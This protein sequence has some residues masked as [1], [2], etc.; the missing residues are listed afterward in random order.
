M[1]D[2]KEFAK[3]VK[4]KYPQY[5]DVDDLTLSQKMIE[6]YPEYKT[7]VTFDSQSTGEVAPPK[8]KVETQPTQQNQSGQKQS[9]AYDKL[10]SGLQ[11]NQTNVVGTGSVP[12]APLKA[13]GEQVKKTESQKQV[14]KASQA[15]SGSGMGFGTTVATPTTSSTG[16]VTGSQVMDANL[17]L[18]TGKKQA[19]APIVSG[20][21]EFYDNE[22][23]K[24][25]AQMNADLEKAGG[26]QQ[27]RQQVL[28]QYTPQIKDLQTKS[29]QSKSIGQQFVEVTKPKPKV[30]DINLE[31]V[32]EGRANVS[33]VKES[34]FE[35][36]LKELGLD[37]SGG[38][39]ASIGLNVSHYNPFDALDNKKKYDEL[40]RA[41]NVDEVNAFKEINLDEWAKTN[42]VSEKQLS[43]LKSKQEAVKKGGK[44]DMDEITEFIETSTAYDKELYEAG[45]NGETMEDFS[46]RKKKETADA[47]LE[48]LPESMRE[49]NKELFK[50]NSD[51]RD[52]LSEYFDVSGRK[53]FKVD[54]KTGE[55]DL[56][57]LS[58]MD[59]EFVESK[60]K[61]YNSSRDKIL[62]E[63]N[64]TVNEEILNRKKQFSELSQKIS[65]AEKELQ[66][67]TDV[68]K[69]N[70]YIQAIDNAKRTKDKLES[71]IGSLQRSKTSFFS[72]SAKTIAGELSSS[73]TAKE[74]YS[75]LPENLS[76]KE[77]SD[78]IYRRL[79]EKNLELAKKYNID[80]GRLDGIG[81]NVRDWL[82]IESLGLSLTPQEKEY[83]ANQRILQSMAPIYF[84]NSTG[85]TEES[86][87]FVES[88]MSGF[89]SFVKPNTGKRFSTQT[90]IGSNQLKNI[91]EQGFTAKDLT[92]EKSLELLEKR[93]SDIPWYSAESLGQA[94]GT[95]GA[96]MADMMV[97]GAV[98]APVKGAKAVKAVISAYDKAMD[99]SK[100]G[101]Y[102]KSAVDTGVNFELTGNIIGS[103]EEELNFIS[104]F[105]G[106]L[107]GEVVGSMFKKLGSEKLTK[108]I[109][110]LFGTKSD[111]AI[112]LLKKAGELNKKGFGEIGEETTQ[113]LIGI[114]N[115]ELRERGF[116]EEVEARYGT[117]NDVMKL[118]A[119]SY[120]MGVGMGLSTS[121]NKI[122]ELESQLTEEERNVVNSV[123]N[124]V[125]ND[126]ANAT[127]EMA[128]T[129]ENVQRVES[130]E[131][132][133]TPVVNEE[134]K[135]TTTTE[136]TTVADGEKAVTETVEETVVEEKKPNIIKDKGN[137]K[138]TEYT[139]DN[140]RFYSEKEVLA[141]DKEKLSGLTLRNPSEAV[142]GYVES[143]F[144]AEKQV[145]TTVKQEAKTPFE[146]NAQEKFKRADVKSSNDAT[147]LAVTQELADLGKEMDDNNTGWKIGNIRDDVSGRLVVDVVLPDG[148]TFLMYK[149][150]GEGSGVE[151]KGEWVPLP[152]FAENGWFVKTGFNPET[153]QSFSGS[154]ASSEKFNP[155][156]NKYGSTKF[157][158]I[159]DY[160]K[161]NEALVFSEEAEQQEV[162]QEAPRTNEQEVVSEGNPVL[163]DV[164]STA[165]ALEGGDIISKVTEKI[166]DIFYTGRG[167]KYKDLNKTKGDFI[168]FSKDKTKSEWYGGDKSRVSEAFI[169][170]SEYIDLTSQEKKSE[171][172]D[173]NFTDED[174]TNLYPDLK[175]KAFGDRDVRKTYEQKLKELI[176]KK[177]E[178]LKENRFSGDNKEQKFL[179]TKAKQLGIKGIKLLDT[180]F[181]QEDI[182][183][184]AIDKSTIKTI[185]PNTVSE[186]YHKAKADGSNPELV[187]VVEELLTQK[188]QT[189]EQAETQVESQTDT[190]T[191]TVQVDEQLSETEQV[192]ESEKSAEEIEVRKADISKEIEKLENET[193][194]EQVLPSEKKE[195]TDEEILEIWNDKWK[196]K[197]SEKLPWS[198]LK[199]EAEKE[200]L[201]EAKANKKFL[202][203][204]VQPTREQLKERAFEIF[205]RNVRNAKNDGSE[206]VWEV[207]DGR[208]GMDTKYASKNID[209]YRKN[210]NWTDRRDSLDKKENRKKVFY[211]EIYTPNGYRSVEIVIPVTDITESGMSSNR[212]SIYAGVIIS[213]PDGVT[214]EEVALPI[215]A[216]AQKIV[217]V[218]DVT[219][220]STTKQ[221]KDLAIPM[222]EKIIN[223]KLKELKE[224]K[225]KIVKV[226]N[227]TKIQEL[228]QELDNLDKI[229]KEKKEAEK[230]EAEKKEAEKKEAEKKEAE[231]KEAE[232][233]EAEKKEAEKKEAEK[234]AEEVVEI[235]EKQKSKNLK[236]AKKLIEKISPRG[237]LEGYG[238]SNKATRQRIIELLTGKKPTLAESGVNNMRK[239]IL[240]ASGINTAGMSDAS[241]MK[242]ITDWAK[243]KEEKVVEEKVETQKDK[244]DRIKSNPPSNAYESALSYFIDGGKML[245][246]AIDKLYGNKKKDVSGEKKS[247]LSL[248]DNTNG[249]SIDDIAHQLWEDYGDNLGL[250]TMDFRN[251]LEGV[252]NNFNS[253]SEMVNEYDSIITKNEAE[254][255]E[256][257]I[258]REATEEIEKE[259]STI[260]N[261]ISFLED[262]ESQLDKFGKETL[263]I[264]IPV[265]ILKQAIV[266]AKKSLQAG[267]KVAEAFSD[268]KSY[269]QNT[270]WFK[271]KS[272]D[273]KD[274]IIDKFNKLVNNEVEFKDIVDTREGA[275]KPKGKFRYSAQ[276]KRASLMQEGELSAKIKEVSKY[277]PQ[278]QKE[279][280]EK[281]NELLDL[282]GAEGAIDYVTDPKNKMDADVIIA[283][284]TEGGARVM[285]DALSMK[286]EAI[287]NDDMELLEVAEN[288]I[289][290]AV[291]YID[292]ASKY[293]TKSGQINAYTARSYEKYPHVFSLVKS[294]RLN[295]KY[296]APESVKNGITDTQQGITNSVN[297]VVDEDLKDEVIESLKSKVEE[298][299]K[300]LSEKRKSRGGKQDA[301]KQKVKEIREKRKSLFDQLKNTKQ[302]SVSIAGISSEQIEIVGKI[303][304]SYIE[305]GVVKTSII[306]NDIYKSIK[307]D[308]PNIRKEHILQ[309]ARENPDFE[310]LRNAE[311]D[312][313]AK[314]KDVVEGEL[315]PSVIR[316]LVK[317]F[318]AGR[319]KNV[320]S[321]AEALAQKSGKPIDEVQTLAD[322]IEAKLND[323]IQSIV[324]KEHQKF[325]DSQNK[326]RLTTEEL[327]KKRREGKISAE[328]LAELEKRISDTQSRKEQA[329]IMKLLKRGKLSD[330]NEFAEAFQKRFGYRTLPSHIRK[331][332]DALALQL[333]DLQ[334]EVEKEIEVQGV[335]HKI[336]TTQRFKIAR[337]QKQ[338]NTILDVQADWNFAKIAK[339]LVSIQYV[340][341]LSSYLTSVRATVGGYISG[342]VGFTSYTTRRLFTDPRA[343]I[344]GMVAMYKSLPAAYSRAIIARKTGQDMFGESAAKG[345]VG[346]ESRGWIERNLLTG[347][348]EDFNNKK[349]GKV[350]FKLIGQLLTNIKNLGSLD[351]FMNTLSGTYVGTIEAI[352]KGESIPNFDADLNKIALDEFNQIKSDAELEVKQKNP[353]LAGEKLQEEITRIIRRDMGITGSRLNAKKTYIRNRVQ[354]LKENQ[355]GE[356]FEEGVMLSKDASMMSTP[357][358]YPGLLFDKAKPAFNI[359]N[360]DTSGV[361]M[362]KLFL[363]LI[364]KFP[365]MTA[366]LSNKVFNN[367]PLIGIANAY[368]GPGYNYKTKEFDTKFIGGRKRA[369]PLLFE[370]RVAT[371]LM[372]STATLIIFNMMFEDD[373]EE[374]L[375]LRE[376]RLFDFRGFGAK[377]LGGQMENQRVY[378]NWQNVSISF[379]RDKDNNFTNHVS[380]RLNPELAAIGATIGAFSDILKGDYRLA[381]KGDKELQEKRLKEFRKSPYSTALY[382]TIGDNIRV[383]TEGSFNSIGKI[384]KDITKTDNLAENLKETGRNLLVD[385]ARPIINPAAFQ[386]IT[387][388]VKSV[389]DI[390]K[391]DAKGWEYL[392]QNLYGLEGFIDKDKTDVLGNKYPEEN[393]Y[394]RFLK[395]F[396]GEGEDRKSKY[397]TVALIYKFGKGVDLTKKQFTELG[398]DSQTGFVVTYKIYGKNYRFK[399]SSNDDSL[400][401]EAQKI[402]ETKFNEMVLDN[403]DYLNSIDNRDDLESVMKEM[404][405]ESVKYAKMEIVSKYEDTD[406]IKLLK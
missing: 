121:T 384:Y 54:P 151:S 369:N 58:P 248:L 354:E 81:Q 370:Q 209:K 373:E 199:K 43:Y 143:N 347:L 170:D 403:Y 117:F 50:L 265:A 85:I 279:F 343:V 139:D 129:S 166:K 406:K 309:I 349:Y 377:G 380:L 327:R 257:F 198:F 100:L 322:V 206:F 311:L 253:K 138:G 178:Q 105:A 269:I 153:G 321:L 329:Q 289:E 21:K 146:S 205:K 137:V 204:I 333:F 157:K 352:R 169:D 187:K 23:V 185:T 186:A 120:I 2:Y 344:K 295:A 96:I 237:S 133:E 382:K 351:V 328:E 395:E 93:V 207:V 313:K 16:D 107:G 77:K 379:T 230:K 38:F 360:E 101:R 386:S 385:N 306:V 162:K 326:V 201:E 92:S 181:G 164:E 111:E 149:S 49:F 390:P 3:K 221:M 305:E 57:G 362:A 196:L 155:K 399:Y 324:E 14:A 109:G 292:S 387:R 361:A 283:V 280:S 202:R 124:E 141:M 66:G 24:L 345:M 11:A 144:P 263:G 367:I 318:Y 159:A 405:N 28:N 188:P 6:K 203:K 320:R 4:E 197:G 340:F 110:G 99:G 287:K 298:L 156:F 183:T 323:K 61:E 189:N 212:P 235:D 296:E 48:T 148:R 213:L 239:A 78:F 288:Q 350:P 79:Y 98:L 228:K 35:K 262:L 264:N 73:K 227:S 368:F 378:E 401:D 154:E 358:G 13:T 177:R 123:R 315:T 278:N 330:S 357:D 238:P 128:E 192:V 64:F 308:L 161:E 241:I 193:K 277:V 388:T 145:E 290:K 365:R 271:E 113:E 391:K 27:F 297:G 394:E 26:N 274:S 168:F 33:Q 45:V 346:N 47:I 30:G 8:K 74:A 335:K 135:P 104:G 59:K 140:G 356:S 5:K 69:R 381:S 108:Y 402:Q 374:G 258:S 341:M 158:E 171:F 243:A 36:K 83:M 314:G 42:V 84:N 400:K 233:K 88:F 301:Q 147:S 211:E 383:F 224:N 332:I 118:V 91:Q 60:L 276:S 40:K 355:L 404:Q 72:P 249:K 331:Q 266:V 37:E 7:Q 236:E 219:N 336:N 291:D 134:N 52:L 339:E 208:G 268:A 53:G 130:A 163:R 125:A 10:V 152:G 142:S 194:T 102:L 325:I 103:A 371:N 41:R 342:A 95:T 67:I 51:T 389:A 112:A 20:G 89:E 174:I 304:A 19:P 195:L 281:I 22:R 160:L 260:D 126:V 132:I 68:N 300:K 131:E 220:Q 375:K 282:L 293:K 17:S 216:E 76:P 215:I 182:S 261:A 275:D 122:K 217:D 231:K 397:K 218:S 46:Y 200:L 165:K 176:D 55:F 62:R 286:N 86:G 75:A 94:V 1:P 319:I 9:T 234:S 392:A 353:N 115:D 254:A 334:Q 90:I 173:K 307:D 136:T 256:Q 376:D 244:I 70:Q 106:S 366:S 222:A 252:I 44:L 31:G 65:F 273:D 80:Q 71:E 97:G 359:K 251:A 302:T 225:T 127:S 316:G 348:G 39:T 232:K 214:A 56:S 285:Q 246:D 398:K 240:E 223:D 15:L 364:F 284:L 270:D 167:E 25:E 312:E 337:L 259:K 63:T 226:D 184:I 32:L 294:K 34:E 229:S 247:R 245:S 116:W 180:F 255:A 18:L 82:D 303:V 114:Y 179:L 310:T 393:D 190:E 175:T 87:G 119:T 372:I 242:A 191:E 12:T 396:L 363:N 150:T 250:D 317:D 272:K 299:E 210:L 172:V 267:K 338:L 29:E